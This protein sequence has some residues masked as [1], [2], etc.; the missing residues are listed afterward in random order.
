MATYTVKILNTTVISMKVSEHDTKPCITI[1]FVVQAL[2][3]NDSV[4][5]LK[6][7]FTVTKAKTAIK[8]KIKAHL[9][10]LSKQIEYEVTI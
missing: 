7:E 5:M 1:P 9:T 8:Q 6:E 2:G 3:L 4:V 10:M